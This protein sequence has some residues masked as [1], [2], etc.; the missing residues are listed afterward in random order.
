MGGGAEYELPVWSAGGIPTACC[1]CQRV[2]CRPSGASVTP[3][4]AGDSVSGCVVHFYQP[5]SGNTSKWFY[6]D[7]HRRRCVMSLQAMHKTE[8]PF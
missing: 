2:S 1:W 8:A 6:P 7:K 5:F 4:Q 3:T